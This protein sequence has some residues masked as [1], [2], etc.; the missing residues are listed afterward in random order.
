MGKDFKYKSKADFYKSRAWQL[1]NK[2]Q[3]TKAIKEYEECLKWFKKATKWQGIYNKH[4]GD[5][6][7]QLGQCYKMMGRTLKDENKLDEAKEKFEE[8]LKCFREAKKYYYDATRD[9]DARNVSQL[10]RDMGLNIKKCE[11]LIQAI[12]HQGMDGF[13][14]GVPTEMTARIP[15]VPERIPGTP[16]SMEFE[17]VFHPVEALIPPEREPI[18][19]LVSERPLPPQNQFDNTPSSKMKEPGEETDEL[20]GDERL[21]PQQLP[22]EEVDGVPGETMDKN[23]TDE[24]G[25]ITTRLS[26][27]VDKINKMERINGPGEKTGFQLDVDS[28]EYEEGGEGEKEMGGEVEKEM[29]KEEED[30]GSSYNLETRTAPP[31]R[32]PLIGIVNATFA[33]G[34]QY[35]KFNK[36][37]DALKYF[38]KALK[39]NPSDG[40]IQRMTDECRSHLRRR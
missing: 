27:L 5:V 1:Y 14:E 40:E 35:Y 30:V 22:E 33:I 29:R 18:F 10:E 13:R 12:E 38:E 7:G 4:V 24:F 11:N 34:M 20:P 9:P 25:S 16:E 28:Q 8:A 26:E 39:D 2:K 37:Q 19:E 36:Y 3:Y 31:Q 32:K 17:P 15:G 23:E 21:P 6:L